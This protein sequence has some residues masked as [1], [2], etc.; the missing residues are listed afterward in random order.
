MNFKKVFISVLSLLLILTCAVL[1]TSRA[2]AV[3][4]SY[5]YSREGS[6]FNTVFTS[7]DILELIGYELSEGERSYLDAYGALNVEYETVTTQQISVITVDGVTRVSARAYSY[8]GVN[9]STVTW[10]PV[11]AAIGSTESALAF[12]GEVYVAEFDCTDTADGQAVSVKY[13][14]NTLTVDADDVNEILNVAYSDAVALKGEISSYVENLDAINDYFAHLNLY[15]KYVSDKLIY[16]QKKSAYDKYVADT[17]IYGQDLIRYAEYLDELEEYNR[18]KDNNDN[19]DVNYAKYEA[20]LQK[21]N[22][23]LS[24]LELANLQI[25]MLNDG[26][27]NSVTYLNRQLYGCI[28]ADLV[29]EVV[30]RKDELTA[31]GADSKDIDAC[32]VA[33]ANIRAMLKPEGGTHY[34]NLKT[35]EEKY[36][37][38]VNNYEALRDNFTLLAQ[39]LY[40][41]YSKD[42][43]RL[44][45]HAA[46]SFLGREDYTER[47]SI[48]IAQLIYLCNALSVDPIMSADG[49]KVLDSNLT[50]DYRDS[51]GNDRTNVNIFDLL[52]RE[53]FVEDIPNPIPVTIV[54]VKE[55]TPPQLLELPTPPTEVVKPTE[56]TPVAHPGD[57]PVVV[58]EP[59]RPAAAP[60]SADRLEIINNSI[61]ASLI[62]DLDLGLLDGTRSL[63]TEDVTFTPTVTLTKSIAAADMV[64]VTFTDTD[65]AVITVIGA[66]KGT[67]VNF[68]DALPT[69]S[70][71]I[72]A[73]YVFDFWATSDGVAYNLSSV[74][75]DVILYPAFKPSYKEYGVV[76]K[77]SKYLDV[78]VTGESLSTVPMAHFID[79][80]L[81]SHLGIILTADNVTVSIPYAAVTDLAN[82]GVARFEVFADTSSISSYSC[83]IFAYDKDGN[84]AV[85]VGG[86]SVSLPCSDEVFARNSVLSYAEE[87]GVREVAKSYSSGYVTFVATTRT[88]YSF[89]LKYSIS[90]NSNLS[91]K[92]IA[93]TDATPGETVTL[94]MNIPD[95]MKVDTLYYT[96]LS[97]NSRHTVEGNTFVMPYGNIRLGATFTELEYTVKFVSDGKVI[98]EKGGYKYGDTVRVPN[99]PT[100]ISDEQYSYTFI[101]WSPVIA[102]VTQDVTY[103]AQFEAVPIPKAEEKVSLFKVLFY[104]G[105]TVFILAILIS[106]TLILNKI[107]VINVRGVLNIA[108]RKFTRVGDKTDENDSESDVND[109]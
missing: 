104:T 42:G 73:S 28:F 91:D 83:S 94:V 14:M 24:D 100:K 36:A 18:I 61:Y 80:A 86:I 10:T 62:A 31:I 16:D 59:D 39:S 1:P 68:T 109:G 55:P 58:T 40:G 26:L 57:E 102:T 54:E 69:K 34:T 20:E 71:D 29:D 98:S 27:M 65:G 49:K 19:Y 44:T 43:V 45:M 50:F 105:L 47:L 17:L 107:G 96:L 7:A 78:S 97:D 56:P 2:F 60:D 30:G 84:L 32:A 101:G 72:S 93:P 48:F 6:Y 5:D 106:V 22:K 46:S 67:A 70:E 25:K 75:D 13:S 8:V 66:E 92:I 90:A 35:Q 4:S 108:R 89:E 82:A 37:F 52:E 21:Y 51:Y 74:S 79:V 103:V 53:Q 3:S 77:G 63:L 99:N 11:S 64:E 15:K 95:G 85:R 41:I 12:D 87:D 88:V 23:Y 38:Y 81:D 33:T 76:D 9:G